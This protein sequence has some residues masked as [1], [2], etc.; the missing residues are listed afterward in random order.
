MHLHL[1]LL[2]ADLAS[3]CQEAADDLLVAG[4]RRDRLA[5]PQDRSLLPLERDTT[6]PRDERLLA[7]VTFD[8]DLQALAWPVRCLDGG[9]V[10]AAILFTDEPYLAASVLSSETAIT[11]RNHPSR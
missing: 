3:S 4:E 6:E 2:P 7:L 10:L 1:F 8:A 11:Q 5:V 9:R